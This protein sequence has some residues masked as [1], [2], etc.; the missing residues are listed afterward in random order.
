MF[1]QVVGRKWEDEKVL[2]MMAVIDDVLGERGF[3]PDV[4]PLESKALL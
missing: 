3:G 2:A 1:T 4:S